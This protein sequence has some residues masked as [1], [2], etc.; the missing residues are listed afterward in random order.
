MGQTRESVMNEASLSS[1]ENEYMESEVLTSTVIDNNYGIKCMQ[2]CLGSF[3][4][5]LK[6]V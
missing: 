6:S 3:Q 1:E 5:K 2:C 4:I